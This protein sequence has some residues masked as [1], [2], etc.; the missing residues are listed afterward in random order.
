MKFFKNYINLPGYLL[1]FT[2]LHLGP[3]HIRLHTILTADGTPYLHNHPFHYVSIIL[4]GG[5]I[6]QLLDGE[7]IKTVHHSRFSY[8]VRKSTDFHRI[9]SVKN[10]TKT[11]FFTLN[12][13]NH[14]KL[15]KHGDIEI[16]QSFK[17]PLKP[18]IYKRT[19][20]NGI[21]YAKFEDFWHKGSS[22]PSNAEK[23]SALSIHQVSDFDNQFYIP[24]EK[25][26]KQYT[27][28]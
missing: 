21:I 2:I 11:L 6:E 3:L 14:W 13:E 26:S 5:Y 25:R 27:K 9:L 19:I 28:N 17:T 15:K 1:R 24:L 8:I 18:G 23:E 22:S 10:K 20:N 12:T 4:S 7:N 16:P